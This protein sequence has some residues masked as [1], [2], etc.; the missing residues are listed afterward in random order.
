MFIRRLAGFEL[1]SLR[2]CRIEQENPSSRD[3][4]LAED[5]CA[6]RR[7]DRF[8]LLEEFIDEKHSRG[9]LDGVSINYLIFTQGS[10]AIVDY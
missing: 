7:S 6:N 3:C 4:W 2:F 9:G 1:S 5:S 8:R 10:P